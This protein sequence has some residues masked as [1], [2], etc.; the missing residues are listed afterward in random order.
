[1]QKW[2]YLRKVNLDD[3]ALVKLGNDGWELVCVTSWTE[4][5]C[6]HTFFFKRP[7]P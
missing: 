6:H 5:D 3:E 2:E 1:M 4:Y 7:K